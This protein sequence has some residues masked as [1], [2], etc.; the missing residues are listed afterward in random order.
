[1]G[2]C[3]IGLEWVICVQYGIW[4]VDAIMAD[5]MVQI[6][7]PRLYSIMRLAK[8]RLFR[9]MP[10]TW[11]PPSTSHPPRLLGN[12]QTVSSFAALK[13]VKPSGA[14]RRTSR[15][16]SKPNTII[17]GKKSLEFELIQSDFLSHR[18]AMYI[19]SCV[20]FSSLHRWLLPELCV[21]VVHCTMSVF[22]P[23]YK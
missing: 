18:R 2:T 5:G 19:A 10:S 23:D 3:F 17:V 15:A 1:M 14:Y 9:D 6:N 8:F 7:L 16:T 13:R 20:A 11:P 21:C 4:M 22:K 12:K